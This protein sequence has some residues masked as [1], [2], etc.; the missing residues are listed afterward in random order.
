MDPADA[1]KTPDEL[2]QLA[3]PAGLDGNALVRAS[4]LTAKVDNTAVQ[5]GFQERATPYVKCAD[6]FGAI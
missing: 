2:T 6:T 5:D 1:R 4:K 3:D